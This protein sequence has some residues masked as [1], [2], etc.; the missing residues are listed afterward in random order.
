VVKRYQGLWLLAKLRL[1]KVES[2]GGFEK[3]IFLV[4]ADPKGCA[5]SF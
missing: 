5:W 1:A 4:P 3:G 2:N